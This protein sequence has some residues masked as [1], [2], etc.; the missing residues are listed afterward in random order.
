MLS[1]VIKEELKRV[2]GEA[3]ASFSKEDL[4]CYSY[5]ATN[6]LYSPDAV[7]FPRTAEEI[8]L[9]MKMANAENFPVI[10]RGAGTGFTGGSV[11][12]AGGV[13]LSFERMTDIVE[14]DAENLTAIVEPGVNTWE[15]GQEAAKSGLFYPPDPTSLKFSTIG[16][17]IAECA[18]GPSAVKYGVT[19]DYVLGLEAVLPTGEIIN[20][21][22][23]TVKG[24]V[25]YDLT[26]LLVGS[27]G[28]LAVITK[29]V[30]KLLPLP[31]SSRTLLAVFPD[32][33]GAASAV[34]GIIRCRIIPSTLELVDAV[35]ARSAGEFS[36]G[37][38]TGG[39]L[40]II[41]TDGSP[42]TVGRE[43]GEIERICLEKGA[44]EVRKAS[45]KKEVKELW[46][47]R[48]AISAALLKVRPNKINEDV[49]VPRSRIPELVTGIEEIA[50]RRGLLIASFGHA[51]D[52]NIHVNVMY[53]KKDEEES[54]EADGAVRDV[55]TLTLKLGGTISGEHGVGITKSKYLA[56]ELGPDAIRVMKGI[57]QTFD[58]KGI[59]NPGKIFPDVMKK[60]K[61]DERTEFA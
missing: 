60:E 2:V 23:R 52:G 42:E 31:A 43:A 14:I 54:A 33:N 25:G 57:K 6:T 50:K 9:I 24:V 48:R 32:L 35:S 20:T 18:G 29:A 15:L 36:G 34:A 4:L 3:N 37:L 40:L 46:K 17:N 19:R 51:G 12:V 47:A 5:D 38:P 13:V 58:P 1:R 45:D 56:M 30:L 7:V 10:P 59:L 61:E 21:G 49:V 28:T 41:E 39:P 27:E 16:G 44:V 53:D 11:P 55:F 22:V 26:K 8:S